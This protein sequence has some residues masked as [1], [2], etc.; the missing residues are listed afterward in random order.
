MVVTSLSKVDFTGDFSLVA[1]VEE[2]FDDGLVDL[3]TFSITSVDYRTEE[4]LRE[5]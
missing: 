1:G 4:I 3:I 5:D 2:G